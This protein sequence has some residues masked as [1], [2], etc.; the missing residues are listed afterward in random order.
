MRVVFAANL[1]KL[2]E[3]SRPGGS[4]KW[5]PRVGKGWVASIASSFRKVGEIKLEGVLLC[6]GKGG[7]RRAQ[8]KR[9]ILGPIPLL[10]TVPVEA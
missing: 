6:L 3:L 1:A 8:V 9:A 2:P 7:N 4:E 10:P 5:W